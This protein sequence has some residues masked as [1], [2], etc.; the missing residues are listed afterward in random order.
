MSDSVRPCRQQ[1]IR[2][3]RPWDSPGKNTGVCCHFLLECRKWK[4]ETEI[5]QPCPTLSTPW[6]TAHQAPPS[7]NFP[8]KSTGVGCHCLLQRREP[9]NAQRYQVE[10]RNN[11]DGI[12]PSHKD[13][14]SLA[15]FSPA[16]NIT[17]TN[18]YE[19][20]AYLSNSK[21]ILCTY[22]L[23]NINILW[24]VYISVLSVE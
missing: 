10:T 6:T 2:L 11:P 5:A 19:S 7:R 9:S 21:R 24:L 23:Q 15:H 4:R 17:L 14:L 18:F 8:G 1:P 12:S 13:T 3:P 20:S 16:K 22:L